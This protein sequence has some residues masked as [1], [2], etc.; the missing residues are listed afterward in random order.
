MSIKV[1]RQSGLPI[2]KEA[3]D[4]YKVEFK[5]QYDSIAKECGK[6]MLEMQKRLKDLDVVMNEKY[7]TIEEWNLFNSVEEWNKAVTEYGPIAVGSNKDTGEL[8]MII[9]DQGL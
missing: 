8:I 1:C 6:D 2:G 7:K 5:N 9:L 3:L 4:E